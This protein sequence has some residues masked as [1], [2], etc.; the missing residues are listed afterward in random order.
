[1]V[2]PALTKSG[3]EIGRDIGVC[4]SP[5]FLREGKAIHDFMN[6]DRVV[7]GEYDKASGDVMLH[8]YRDLHAPFLMTTIK[9]AEMIKLASNAYL[10]SKISF[11]NEIG[12]ICKKLGVNINE[13]ARGM[14]MDERIGKRFLFAGVGF[15]GSCLPKDVRGLINKAAETGYQPE[16]LEAVLKTNDAQGLKMLDLLQKHVNLK[17]ATIGLLGLAFKPDTDDIRES[18]SILVAR[19]LLEAGAN[20]KANDPMAMENFQKRYPE[21]NIDFVSKEEVL[22]ADAVLIMTEWQEYEN[23]NYRGK[24]IID[25]RGIEKAKEAGIYEG[26]CW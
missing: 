13:V 7:I 6:P 18:R 20:V 19:R 25:G 21:M 11:I 15:G 12:N 23:L 17:D 1:V 2:I 9:T 8:L 26:I 10:A 24:I 16:V 4:M 3:K 5:E 14:G 22:K